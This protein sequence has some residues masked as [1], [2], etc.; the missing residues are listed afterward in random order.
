MGKFWKGYIW[1]CMCIC[2]YLY[3]FMCIYLYVFIYLYVHICIYLCS[4][5]CVY[6]FNRWKISL[7]HRAWIVFFFVLSVCN[8]CRILRVFSELRFYMYPVGCCCMFFR[9]K[10]SFCVNNG[11]EKKKKKKIWLGNYMS[12]SYRLII[13]KKSSTINID[14]RF[15]P[16]A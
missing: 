7:S 10:F 3:V 13:L 8:I 9:F 4:C 14:G 11:V 6:T 1:I 2:M 12:K 5:I 16:I 15:Q